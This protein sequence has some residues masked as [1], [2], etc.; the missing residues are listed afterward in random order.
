MAAHRPALLLDLTLEV[1]G[2]ERRR[3]ESSHGIR[4]PRRRV[5]VPDRTFMGVACD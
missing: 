2:A 4:T 1:R 3:D 5:S